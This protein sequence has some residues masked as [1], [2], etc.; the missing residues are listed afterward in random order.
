MAEHVLLQITEGVATVTLNRPERKNAF[1]PQTLEELRDAITQC[2]ADAA[3]RVVVLTGAGEAFCSGA[4]TGGFAARQ[5]RTP[6]QR[7]EDLEGGL[8]RVLLALEDLKKPTIAAINGPAVGAGLDLALMC[9]L[10][11]MAEG[12]R[13]G[14]TYVRLGLFPGG[15]ATWSLPR[16][17]GVSRALEMLWT[18]SLINAERAVAIGLADQ[19]FPDAELSARVVEIASRIAAAAPLSVRFMKRAVLDGQDR[20]LRQSLDLISSQ[21]ALLGNSADHKEALEAMTQKRPPNFT[22]V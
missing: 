17:V 5:Q 9:D 13:V 19:S 21:L 4:D 18:G 8:H 2:G 7:K 14:E 1:L 11:Y 15:G 3:V 20:S 6:I 22:G 10:I 12:A 16:R